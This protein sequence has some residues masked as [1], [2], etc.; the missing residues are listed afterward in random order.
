MAVLQHELFQQHL[1]RLPH[2]HSSLHLASSK[3]QSPWAAKTH[4]CL[5]TLL[6]S[7]V[8]APQLRPPSII[9]N[10][11]L[12]YLTQHHTLCFRLTCVA[13]ESVARYSLWPTEQEL[14][15]T[16]G[17]DN[18][19]VLIHL[20]SFTNEP[21]YKPRRIKW[22]ISYWLMGF[23]ETSNYWCCRSIPNNIREVKELLLRE[24]WRKHAKSC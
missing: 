21:I 24:T 2:C 13:H 4:M 17:E 23:T 7:S 1:T 20:S 6:S 14:Q 15:G 11:A 3:G 18:L 5:H 16:A 19:H 8:I 12:F 10:T 9:A 22:I